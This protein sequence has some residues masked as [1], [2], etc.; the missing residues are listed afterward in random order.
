MGLFSFLASHDYSV[1][2]AEGKLRSAENF[3][4][5]QKRSRDTAK[6]NGNY[7]RSGKNYRWGDKVGNV[8]DWNVWVAEKAVKEAKAQ[9]AAAKKRK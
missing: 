6:Q 7:R 4:A 3:L 2:Q 8:Y 1:S 9:L 5:A